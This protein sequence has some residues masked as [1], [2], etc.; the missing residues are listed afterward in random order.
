[1]FPST[2]DKGLTS[3]SVRHRSKI[4]QSDAEDEIKGGMSAE[5][6]QTKVSRAA[7]ISQ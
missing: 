3:S 7:G 2:I 6:S 1:M 4:S 5:A